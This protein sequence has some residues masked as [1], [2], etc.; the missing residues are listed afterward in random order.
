MEYPNT[1]LELE[2]AFQPISGAPLVAIVNDD[3]FDL[4]D[5]LVEDTPNTFIDIIQPIVK[6]NHY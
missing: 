2:E 1:W 6:W 3:C 5:P 4:V